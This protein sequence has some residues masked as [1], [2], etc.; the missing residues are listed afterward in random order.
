[1]KYIKAALYP[2]ACSKSVMKVK[3][4]DTKQSFRG[5]QSMKPAGT[6]NIFDLFAFI[7][8]RDKLYNVRVKLWLPDPLIQ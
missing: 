7:T 3:L 8:L 1:M 5:G 6:F 2:C 4:L